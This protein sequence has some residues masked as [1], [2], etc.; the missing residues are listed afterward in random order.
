[1]STFVCLNPYCLSVNNTGLDFSKQNHVGRLLQ[2]GV[3]FF[4]TG[5]STKDFLC[6][7]PSCHLVQDERQLPSAMT[8]TLNLLDSRSIFALCLR[9]RKFPLSVTTELTLEN[10][11]GCPPV[12]K[13]SSVTF[14]DE[15]RLVCLREKSIGFH[16]AR[17]AP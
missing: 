2:S 17:G 13:E 8:E 12:W 10:P 6:Q 11:V 4:L 14:G 9:T 7:S 3:W 5:E 15:R 16:T 1:M